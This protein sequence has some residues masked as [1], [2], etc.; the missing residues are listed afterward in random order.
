M[1]IIQSAGRVLSQ[2]NASRLKSVFVEI[3]SILVDA[4]VLDHEDLKEIVDSNLSKTAD[5]TE[6]EEKEEELE[7]G[8]FADQ[9]EHRTWEQSSRIAIDT[10]N[11]QFLQLFQM[12]DM[13]VAQVYDSSK[14][15]AEIASE[16]LEDLGAFMKSQIE[17]YPAEVA[18]RLNKNINNYPPYYALSKKE[19]EE[20]GSIDLTF[21]C[22]VKETLAAANNISQIPK[23]L[24]NKL[25]IE[26]V[27]F[28]VDEVSEFAPST[29]S[30]L[31][32]YV[33][34][35]V[36]VAAAA[37]INS[38]GGLPLD[39]HDSLSK[40]A[41]EEIVGIMN[42]AEIIGNEFWVRGHLFP[43]NKEKKVS[44]IAAN[45]KVLGMS[46]NA[47][48]KTAIRTIDGQQVSY[49]S[50]LDVLGANILYADKATYQ[51]T[52]TNVQSQL[53]A[54][55]KTTGDDMELEDQFGAINDTLSSISKDS[56]RYYETMLQLEK[57]VVAQDRLLATLLAERKEHEDAIAAS[58]L[59]ETKKQ[60]RDGLIQA[61]AEILSS[62]REKLKAE[63]IDSVAPSN[64][65]RTPP[66]RVTGG[67]VDIV[68]SGVQGTGLSGA[69]LELHDAK[70]RLNTLRQAGVVGSERAK[71]IEQISGLEAQLSN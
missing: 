66:Q 40:H 26:G 18:E 11:S 34:R 25:P 5:E 31:P 4:N 38:S 12:S 28:F 64:R 32:L 50:S 59:E 22:Q 44:L 45:S 53:I 54:A 61:V 65:R 39:A 52:K 48:A 13:A 10:F 19:D 70:I 49:I 27:L 20:E 14:T 71:L 3:G 47:H 42:Q 69:S 17:K 37:S 68:A 55:S 23:S 36:A 41:N 33:P 7:A 43:W 29:G 46:M 1:P 15:R 63:I 16:M 6:D 8:K 67:L 57:R 9:L 24:A 56:E 51:K 2:Q 30:S 35:S 60:E 21:N 62:D 58:K